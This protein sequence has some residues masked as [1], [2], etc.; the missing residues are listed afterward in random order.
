M[1]GD[2]SR[3]LGIITARGGSK[4]IPGKNI[5]PFLGRPIIGYSLEAA[6]KSG[7]FAELMVSTDDEEIAEVAR[8]LGASV[9]F[10]RSAETSDDHAT[11]SDVVYEVLGEY[12]G[13]GRTF[14]FCCCI[15]PTAPFITAK[16]LRRGLEILIGSGADSVIPVVPF[17]FPVQRAL[18][19]DE[20]RLVFLYPEH[21]STRS[22]DLPASFHDSGQFY[23]IRTEAFLRERTLFMPCTLPL[24]L[25]ELEVQDIDTAD[26]WAIAEIK[27]RVLREAGKI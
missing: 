17:S 3:S 6:L 9:P 22:Q 13:R 15:Y 2:T 12:A 18:G 23:W 25:P 10:M 16:K 21:R 4:R 24:V 26:D 5:K 27:M 8:A 1:N 20:G 14:D 7:C 11:T 19:I